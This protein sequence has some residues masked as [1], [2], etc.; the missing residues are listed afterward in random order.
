MFHKKYSILTKA[1]KVLI[2]RDI[3]YKSNVFKQFFTY[4]VFLI[5][6]LSFIGAMGFGAVVKYHYDGG[7]KFQ[8][9]QKPVVLI[10]SV[11]LTLRKNVSKY[12]IDW[13]KKSRSKIQF[14]VKQFLKPHWCYQVCFEEFP[15]FGSKMSVDILNATKKIAIEV[16]G[17]Q[18]KKFNKFFHNN[19]LILL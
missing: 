5:L 17:P 9:L 13:E 3:V 18:H 15:V 10:S 11:P 1:G 19:L 4:P 14:A 6:F 7:K 12:K 16:N 2:F 8:F